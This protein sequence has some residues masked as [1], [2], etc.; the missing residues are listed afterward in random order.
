MPFLDCHAR[1]SIAEKDF[2]LMATKVLKQHSLSIEIQFAEQSILYWIVWEVSEILNQTNRLS[3]KCIL[4][5]NRSQFFLVF[6]EF[7]PFYFLFQEHSA[8]K[9][10]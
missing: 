4:S 2:Y 8:A 3:E 1:G 9:G 7:N 6:E 10:L 5:G